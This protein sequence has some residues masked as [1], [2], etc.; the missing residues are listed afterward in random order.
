MKKSKSII[1]KNASELAKA[2]GLSSS[3]AVEWEVR[4]SVTKK[5]IAIV[6]KKSLTITLLAKESGTSRARVTKILKGETAGISLD[7]LFRVLG[8]TGQK[9][10]LSYKKAA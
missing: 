5:I 10:K 7:V 3:D 2:L 1:T 8:A 6:E 4:H 9:V